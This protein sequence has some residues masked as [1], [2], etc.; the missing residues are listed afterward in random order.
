M[1]TGPSAGPYRELDGRS[2]KVSTPSGT[3]P[4][5]RLCTRANVSI[6]TPAP[7]S[8]RTASATSVTTSPARARRDRPPPRPSSFSAVDSS[9]PPAP[10]AGT[11]VKTIV[12]AAV[13]AS[14]KS[15][16]PA[17]SAGTPKIAIAE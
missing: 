6:N 7:T 13:A 17:S 9:S 8:S 16:T 14:V 3:N 10:I 4:P 2:Q 1:M 11:S 12:V 5:R 15:S